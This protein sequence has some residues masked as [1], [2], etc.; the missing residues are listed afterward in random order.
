MFD[1]FQLDICIDF[2]R[3]V[4]NDDVQTTVV[5]VP[6]SQSQ[7]EYEE[8]CTRNAGKMSYKALARFVTEIHNMLGSAR[9]QRGDGS[10]SGAGRAEPVEVSAHAT[11]HG[12]TTWRVLLPSGLVLRL[13]HLGSYSQS[14]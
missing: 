8:W 13:E 6:S 7:S 10:T 1:G 12:V 3:C 5:K 9:G 14:V 2:Q 11:G 4:D